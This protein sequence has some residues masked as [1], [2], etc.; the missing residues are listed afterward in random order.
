MDIQ[1][2]IHGKRMGIGSGG[3]LIMDKGGV[4]NI[5]PAVQTVAAA[6]AT[7]A[8]TQEEHAGTTIVLGAAAVTATLPLCIG[9]GD[10]YTFFS[11]FTATAQ[12]ITA[13]G[14]ADS[15]GGGVSISTNI[16]GVT[17]L[18][19]ATTDTC[20][21]NGTTT[22]GVIGSWVRFTDVAVGKWMVEG[23]LASTGTEATPWSAT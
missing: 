10:T 1:T 13:N 2:S 12:I 3:Q 22:G 16:T 18:C 14:A 20:T 15:F 8:V 17:M 23:F 5:I 11:N 9:G 21:M 4:Q 19:A 6:A 7:L